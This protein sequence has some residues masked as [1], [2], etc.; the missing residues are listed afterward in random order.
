M[1]E[2]I[3]PI[4]GSKDMNSS[5]VSPL[6]NLQKNLHGLGA[7]MALKRP[8]QMESGNHRDMSVKRNSAISKPITGLH[9][10]SQV[11]IDGAG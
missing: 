4:R 3:N 9:Q 10:S 6:N 8:S 11:G 2:L 1:Q 7:G 5:S